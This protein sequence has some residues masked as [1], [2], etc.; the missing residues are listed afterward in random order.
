MTGA[1][2]TDDLLARFREGDRWACGRLITLAENRDPGF[3]ALLAQVWD[4]VGDAWR[5]GITDVRIIAA[6]DPR[7]DVETEVLVQLRMTGQ[8]SWEK[9]G[10]GA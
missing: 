7:I 9:L 8:H 10:I 2:T 1:A 4:G 3:P 5:T 6:S